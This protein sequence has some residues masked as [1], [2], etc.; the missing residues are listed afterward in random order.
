VAA[1]AVRILT[2]DTH[3]HGTSAAPFRS[4]YAANSSL[5][6]G[7]TGTSV[8]VVHGRDTDQ[9]ASLWFVG[10]TPQLVATSA[11]V[12]LNSPS[13]PAQGL[14]G[15]SDPAHNAYGEYAAGVWLSALQS[16]LAG[17]HWTWPDPNTVPGTNVPDVSGLSLA[18]A[19]KKLADAGFRMQ[20]LDAAGGVECASSET[21]GDVAF[22]GPHRA[23]KG[24]TIT[25]CPS[26][27]APQ[28]VYVPPPPPPPPTYY[29]PPTPI[30]LPPA[31]QTSSSSSPPPT[32]AARVTHAPRS[33]PKPKPK[34][35]KPRPSK[36]KPSKSKRPGH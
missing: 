28:D 34:P 24:T 29:P 7:K 2:G 31:P 8:A 1:Q 18:A 4:W 30:L 5:V 20:Q 27:G 19:R 3:Y 12:N 10:M 13:S 25:V 11:V 9:N 22:Y 17:Q 36:P 14:P 15:V 16:S 21:L 33:T 35:T 23:V 32:R 26:S 6:A